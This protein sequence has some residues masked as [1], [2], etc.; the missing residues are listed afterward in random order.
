MVFKIDVIVYNKLE[1]KSLKEN[2][3]LFIF[4]VTL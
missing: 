2:I 3:L 1:D 4:V